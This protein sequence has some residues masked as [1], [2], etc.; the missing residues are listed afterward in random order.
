MDTE[1]KERATINEAAEEGTRTACLPPLH[2]PNTG[3]YL[4]KTT[5]IS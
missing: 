1:L 3:V 2:F 5:T 4:A